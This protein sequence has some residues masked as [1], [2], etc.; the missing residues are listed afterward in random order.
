MLP[1][2]CKKPPCRNIE[3]TRVA[4]ENA[5]G[6]NPYPMMNSLTSGPSENSYPNTSAFSA[7]IAMVTTGVVRDGMTSRSGIIGG[8]QEIRYQD[9]GIR[10]QVSGLGQESAYPDL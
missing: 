7:I 2:K 6:I 8:S 4:Q 10:Y 5:A 3:V 9:S 1:A